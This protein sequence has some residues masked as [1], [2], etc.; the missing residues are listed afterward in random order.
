MRAAY[1]RY[2]HHHHIQP[3]PRSANWRPLG[4]KEAAAARRED[5]RGGVHR[6]S[7]YRKP[8]IPSC[9]RPPQKNPL[10]AY[11][12]ER[13]RPTQRSERSL[14]LRRA[15][16]PE[17]RVDDR[18]FSNPLANANVTLAALRYSNCLAIKTRRV[19]SRTVVV[20]MVLCARF[21]QAEK[22]Q[23]TLKGGLG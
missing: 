16:S 15:A 2:H 1:A 6:R 5:G 7:R 17:A 13:R 4:R 22:S 23:G 14:P 18:P 9:S 21:C 8:Q 10:H 3:P 19:S 20:V 12:A 11:S